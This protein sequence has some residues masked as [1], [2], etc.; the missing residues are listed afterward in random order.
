MNRV[1]RQYAALLL[2]L[3]GAPAMAMYRC[4]NVFQDKP[5]ESG[6]EIRLSPSGRP[7]TAPSN[8]PVAP[9]V[10]AA[11]AAP[12]AAA[13]PPPF[14]AACARIG[15]Q[16]QRIA[17]KREGGASREQQLAEPST[18]LPHGEQAKTIDAV[19]ARRG[20][21]P[22]IRATI[23]SE[24]LAEK[25]KEAEAAEMLRH[26]RKQAGEIREAP[27]AGT[28]SPAPVP[29]SGQ[30]RPTATTQPSVAHC[31]SLRE[32]VEHANSRLRQGGSAAAM[33]QLQNERRR[34]EESVRSSGCR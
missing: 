13:S 2:I 3:S 20:S 30:I 24:C 1:L 34:A 14:A 18:V 6:K 33:E 32:V 10:P 23:Q 16:A 27:A 17:W 7:A 9:A 21:A 28:A 25:Q 15:E 11:P 31:A 5:C 29:N 4:G 12:A 26:L 19:Y 22:E 8:A